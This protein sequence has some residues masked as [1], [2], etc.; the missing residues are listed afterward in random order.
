M[1]KKTES[2][3]NRKQ[4]QRA[5]SSQ[6]EAALLDALEATDASG[7]LAKQR[8]E[9][10][11]RLREAHRM[12]H[13]ESSRRAQAKEQTKTAS[14]LRRHARAIE[15]AQS[16]FRQAVDVAVTYASIYSGPSEHLAA[17]PPLAPIVAAE[18]ATLWLVAELQKRERISTQTAKWYRSKTTQ[19]A[20]QW[21]PATVTV[22]NAIVRLA[23]DAFSDQ[24]KKEKPT[25]Q[26]E[27]YA[28]L[29]CI[30]VGILTVKQGATAKAIAEVVRKRLD[31]AALFIHSGD[32]GA[33]SAATSVIPF[34]RSTGPSTTGRKSPF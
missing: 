18:R 17:V 21:G 27:Y 19:K 25:Q 33:R 12:D 14:A 26:A 24:S 7:H 15:D 22:V 9:V 6:T 28:G 13:L 2:T 10:I 34:P 30:H 8:P 31:R 32:H 29:L 5:T 11:R 23:Q 3:P 1:S 20:S 16:K 4:R